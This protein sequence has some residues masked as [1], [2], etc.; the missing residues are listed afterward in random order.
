MT[1]R[2]ERSKGITAIAHLTMEAIVYGYLSSPVNLFGLTCHA[3]R[4]KSA[5]RQFG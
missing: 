2:F 3:I 1:S 4:Y 5:H